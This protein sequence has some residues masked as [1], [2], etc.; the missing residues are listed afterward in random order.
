MTTRRNDERTVA[1]ERRMMRRADREV[2]DPAQ[3]MAIVASCKIIHIAYADAEGPTIV[4]MNFAY[5]CENIGDAARPTFYFHSAPI[6]RK[7]D[8]IKAAGNK[9]SVAFE[10]ETDCEVVAGRVPCNWGEAFKS[11]VGTGVASIVSDLDE[12]RLA[13]ELLMRQQAGMEH[14]EF[15]DRQV[16]SV[17]AWKVESD[18]VTAKVRERPQPRQ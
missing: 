10:M 18:Y 12:S 16:R 15:T 8:A 5:I 1:G 11:V 17:T 6:G 7:I 4:P 9:L 14:V 13:L 3:I 2:A